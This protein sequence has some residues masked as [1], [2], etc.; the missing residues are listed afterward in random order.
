[1]FSIDL[2]LLDIFDLLFLLVCFHFVQGS[3]RI[4]DGSFDQML[5]KVQM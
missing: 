2:A 3:R 4:T 5:K 1:M